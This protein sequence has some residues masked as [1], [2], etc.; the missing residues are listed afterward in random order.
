[1]LMPEL[2][3][4]FM[5]EMQDLGIAFALDDFGAG[6]T[7][8]RYLRD[9]YFDIL[10]I[11]GQFIKGIAGHSDNQVLT[12]ALVMIGK[13]FDMFTIAEGVEDEVDADFL[14]QID[15]DCIQGYITG[16]PSL[17][18]PIERHEGTRSA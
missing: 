18:P 17:T 4:A 8:F 13:H 3:I 11:D 2:V 12:E 14:S 16:A 6:Y 7:A 1:M 5:E 15:L 10:K 9:F